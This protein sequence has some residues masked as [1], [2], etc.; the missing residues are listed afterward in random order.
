MR[1]AIILGL[2]LCLFS[3][4]PAWA[5]IDVLSA[6]ANGQN[7]LH[8]VSADKLINMGGGATTV[9]VGDILV[10]IFAFNT[11]QNPSFPIPTGIGTGS[12][13]YGELSGLLAIKVLTKT[14]L[15][16]GAYSW[17]FGPATDAASVAAINAVSPAA[18]TQIGSWANGTLLAFFDD[19]TPDFSR[20]GTTVNNDVLT[21]IDGYKLWEL[22]FTNNA[23][24]DANGRPTAQNGQG[25]AANAVSDDVGIIGSTPFPANGGAVNFS[26]D[27][28][29]VTPYSGILA[30]VLTSIFN[31]LFK[32]L[33]MNGSA[34]LLGTQSQSTAWDAFDNA[35]VS[36]NVTPEPL[37]LLVW[38]GMFG[39]GAVILRS[40]LRPGRG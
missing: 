1:K 20:N 34:N 37:S 23:T 35:D 39:F 11:I 31:P 21:A 9:D 26:V 28:T 6:F 33:E 27:Q 16:G 36:I 32:T 17:T 7:N 13:T 22:G 12:S 29:A 14:S 24:L 18:G 40:H 2:A 25:W 15:G 38:L 5:S 3:A 4:V 19:T 10:S 30:P 8:D